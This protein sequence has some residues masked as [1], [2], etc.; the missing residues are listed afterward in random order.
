MLNKGAT[1]IG[2]GSLG[3]INNGKWNRNAC[4]KEALKYK[5][6][7]EFEK[8]NGSAYAAARR[9]GWIKDYITMPR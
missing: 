3:A 9:N 6:C 2:K 5:S 8:A 1:G 4:Y 7:S